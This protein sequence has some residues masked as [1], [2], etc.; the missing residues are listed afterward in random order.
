MSAIRKNGLGHPNSY[1]PQALAGFMP[2]AA[3]LL[4]Q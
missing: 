2:R 3:G 4:F 1:D